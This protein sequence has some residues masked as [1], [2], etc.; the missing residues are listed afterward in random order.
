MELVNETHTAPSTRP[1][2]SS[3]GVTVPSSISTIHSL[4][5][6]SRPEVAEQPDLALVRVKE[7]DDH[8]HGGGLSRAVWTDKAINRA[9]GNRER[10]VIGGRDALER[11]CDVAD[12]N[13]AHCGES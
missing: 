1:A 4:R 13:G 8:P 2:I 12:L 9:F 3:S 6:S 11:F 10:E 7:V 5:A